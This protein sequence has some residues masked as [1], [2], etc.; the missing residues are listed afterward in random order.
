MGWRGPYVA[1]MTRDAP[2]RLHSRREVF[3]AL[4]WM[5]H[6]GAAWR[7][8]PHGLT[9][10]TNAQKRSQVSQLAA[11]VQDATGD[12]VAL[13]DVDQGY[14][15]NQVVQKARVQHR[16]REVG[17]VPEAKK[18]LVLLPRRWV[19]ARRLAW[20]GRFRRLAR[21]DKPLPQTL[22]GL[23]GVACTILM[24]KRFVEMIL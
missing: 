4:R 14:T 6:A 8:M 11:W 12:A 9:T 19:V 24:L 13:A 20:T 18:G 10:L 2:H 23:H 21:D 17:K 7:L 16:E 15:D 5:V 1:L 22:A 3:H